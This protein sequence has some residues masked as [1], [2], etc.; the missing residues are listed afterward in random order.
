ML[1]INGERG[2]GPVYIVKRLGLIAGAAMCFASASAQVAAKTPKKAQ[3]ATCSGPVRQ[4]DSAASLKRRYGKQAVVQ[5]VGGPEG[6]DFE[7]LVLWP[8]DPV[9][10]IEVWFDDPGMSKVDQLRIRSPHSRWL[11]GGLRLGDSVERIEPLNGRRF[12]ISGFS[13]DYGGAVD[14]RGG[15]LS[16]LP[17][18]CSLEVRLA[19]PRNAS[20]VP[21]SLMGEVTLSSRDARV[22]KVSPVIDE[23]GIRWLSN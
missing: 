8:G 5:M 1:W 23:M 18:G 9:R 11:M 17:G 4:T 14:W 15:K 10:R 3:I 12:N 13:W 20:D 19:I 16:R 7:A 21:D 22:R 2:F 6:E